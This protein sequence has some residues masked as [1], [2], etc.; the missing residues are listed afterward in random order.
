MSSHTYQTK[1]ASTVVKTVG[2]LVQISTFSFL[3]TR[4]DTLGKGTPWSHALTSGSLLGEQ[5]ITS[6]YLNLNTLRFCARGSSFA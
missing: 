3:D 1:A 6:Y 5:E 2:H 4:L